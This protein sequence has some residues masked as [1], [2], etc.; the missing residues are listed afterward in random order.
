MNEVPLCSGDGIAV[1]PTQT[2]YRGD[3]LRRN[4]PLLGPYGSPMVIPWRSVFL[5]SEVP[6]YYYRWELYGVSS[7][8]LTICIHASVHTYVHTYIRQEGRCTAT[9]KCKA[10]LD[11]RLLQM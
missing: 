8:I 2:L 11:V 9:W 7:K 4:I 10:T 1:R 3:S 5:I 6:L